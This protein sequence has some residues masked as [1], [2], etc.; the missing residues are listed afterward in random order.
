MAWLEARFMRGVAYW[1][2]AS[3]WGD[4]IIYNNTSDLVNNYVIPAN[5]QI[6]VMEFAVRD[7]EYAAA[8]LPETSPATGRVN[9]VQRLRYALTRISLDG[10]TYNRRTI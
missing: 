7:L 10:G 1:Y 9:K 4:A 6:D 2:I 3:L 5:P 8:N